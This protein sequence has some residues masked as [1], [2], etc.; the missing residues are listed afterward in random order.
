MFSEVPAPPWKTSSGNWSRHAFSF[1]MRSQAAM[2]ASAFSGSSL[3]RSAFAAAAAF[4]TVTMPLIAA[5]NSFRVCPLMRKF[6][7]ARSVWTPQ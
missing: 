2:M 7:L 4:L 3:P 6:S 1:R 5:G